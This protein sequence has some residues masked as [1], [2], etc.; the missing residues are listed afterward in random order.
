MKVLKIQ[1]FMFVIDD[2]GIDRWFIKW[3]ISLSLGMMD[4]FM[5]GR[6]HFIIL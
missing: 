6:D 4:I 5:H 2:A 1:M 3:N